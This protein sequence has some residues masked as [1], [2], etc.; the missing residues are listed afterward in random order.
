[1]VVVD[2]SDEP[3][4]AFRG[5]DYLPHSSLGIPVDVFVYTAAEANEWDPSYRNDVEDGI[6]LYRRPTQ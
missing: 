5:S 3:V 2:E 4:V 1:M 6:R